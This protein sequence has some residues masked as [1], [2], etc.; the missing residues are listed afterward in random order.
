[1]RRIESPSPRLS[2]SKTAARSGTIQTDVGCLRGFPPNLNNRESCFFGANDAVLNDACRAG[3]RGMLS[4][5]GCAI[6]VSAKT[7]TSSPETAG[8]RGSS[9]AE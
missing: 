5:G 2:L 4:A 1:M 3:F 9:R 6:F 7:S 8:L